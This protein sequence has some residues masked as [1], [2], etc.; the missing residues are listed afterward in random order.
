MNNAPLVSVLMTAY[1]RENYIA[2]AIESV[3]VS[4]YTNFELIVVDDRSTDNTVAI[5]KKYEITDQRVTVYVNEK[6]LGDYRNRN[7]AAS[8][9]TGKY[10]K[11]LDSDDTIYPE[12]LAY[13]VGE[14]EKYPDASFGLAMIDGDHSRPSILMHSE[15]VIRK[16]FFQ[17]THLSAGP[18]GMIIKRQF[19]ENIGGFDPGFRMASDTFFNI[20]A[21]TLTPVVL[22]KN[23]YF[24]YRVHDSQ[25]LNNTKENFIYGYLAM[26]EAL[27]TLSLPLTHKEI[28]FLKKKINRQHAA[29]LVVNMIKKRK[30]KE[31]FFVMKQT[32]YGILNVFRDLLI[33]PKIQ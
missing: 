25:E 27:K 9:A 28:N 12:G 2:E 24:F 33:Q 26:Q 20:K 30:F 22:L 5:A 6:N 4:T 7:H 21:A 32:N 3:L 10:I 8:Y 15:E 19:F 23:R 31:S 17:S 18:T 1:N 29:G 16:H 11:Y 13:A 14:M